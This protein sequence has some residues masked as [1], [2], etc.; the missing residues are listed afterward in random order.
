MSK[1]L[2]VLVNSLLILAIVV[3]GGLLIPPFAGVTTVIVDDG[4]MDTNLSMGSVTYAVSLKEMPK[5][6]SKVLVSEGG[7]QYV[8]RVQSVEGDKCV[9]E[10]KLST[11]GGTMEHT[12]SSTMKKAILTVPLIGY[13]S[14]ALR[15]PEGLIVVG[16][17]VVFIIVLF[18]LAEIWKKDDED[19]EEDG[20]DESYEEEEEPELSRK[21]R[22]AKK[23]RKRR[24]RQEKIR[25]SRKKFLGQRFPKFLM[26]RKSR[27]PEKIRTCLKRPEVF[28]RQISP[29]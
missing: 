8:Y 2:K 18:I 29:G 19:D 15:T 22:K 21:E 28:W 6:G 26:K 16:L 3:A 27:S 11:D 10:D 23:R 14:A 24:K 20:D 4:T 17:S 5:E 1:F 25:R 9:L 13:V 12:V 7:S